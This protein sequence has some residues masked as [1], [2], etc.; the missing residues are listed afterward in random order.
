VTV[1]DL[2]LLGEV[3][4]PR[5]ST[6]GVELR[7][8][9]AGRPESAEDVVRTVSR[10]TGRRRAW[11]VRLDEVV[12]FGRFPQAPSTAFLLGSVTI[13]GV[14]IGRFRAAVP[15]HSPAGGG[16]EHFLFD[17]GGK[18][19]GR[20]ALDTRRISAQDLQCEQDQRR[21]WTR[22][23]AGTLAVHLGREIG[24]QLVSLLEQRAVLP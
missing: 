5:L 7:L 12:E 18:V 17:P 6:V 10:R 14:E 8:R 19:I 1:L 24:G 15:E 23:H 20:I 22:R 11:L 9:G 4:V 13:D 2:H 16:A 3:P 21:L